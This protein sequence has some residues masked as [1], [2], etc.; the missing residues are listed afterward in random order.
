MT[1]WVLLSVMSV[2]LLTVIL[3]GWLNR[4]ALRATL[5]SY[6]QDRER[7]MDMAA[8]SRSYIWE[9]NLD[10]MH[11]YISQSV[12]NVLG[13]EPEEIIGKKMIYDMCVENERDEAKAFTTELLA[14]GREIGNME[15]RQAAK[16]GRVIW[17]LINGR[18]TYDQAGNRTGF[19]GL[20]IDITER[21]HA[22]FSSRAIKERYHSIM[23]ISNTGVWE[24]DHRSEKLWCSEE[25]FSMLGYDTT[26]FRNDV[27]GNLEEAWGDLICPEDQAVARQQFSD[28]FHS[29]TES[30]YENVFRMKRKGGTY[31]WIW[32]RGKMLRDT[33]G[34]PSGMIIG[35]HIDITEMKKLES[36]LYLEKEQ[37]KTTLLSIGEGVISTNKSGEIEVMNQVAEELTGWTQEEAKGRSLAQVYVIKDELTGEPVT[38]LADRVISSGETLEMSGGKT[39][40]SRN[41][42]EYP[43]EDQVTP[44]RNR[45]GIPSGV[46]IVF[47]DFS[48]QKRR[49]LEI[50]Y[51]SY[52][53]QLTGLYNRRFFE[54][55]LIR[56]DSHRN[57]P[58]TIVMLDVNGLKLINDAFGH[59]AGDALLLK[60]TE[61][62][63]NTFRDH[64]VIA[65]IGGDEFAVLLPGISPEV[66]ENR[67]NRLKNDLAMKM[68]KGVN[69]SISTGFATKQNETEDI[70]E[71]LR[72][73]DHQMYQDKVS[74]RPVIR[75]E[76]IEQLLDHFFD[77]YPDEKDHATAVGKLAVEIGEL[78]GLSYEER[79]TIYKAAIFHDI[80]KVAINEA[81]MKKEGLF[82][83][84]EREEV[85]RHPEIG[86]SILSAASEYAPIAEDVL[87]HH[88]RW[89]GNGYPN[90]LKA[91][92]IPLRA[93]ILQAAEVMDELMRH[94]SYREQRTREEALEEIKRH[95]G[96]QFDPR[97][98]KK[99]TAIMMEEKT[100]E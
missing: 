25:Y 20:D 90:G 55:E 10:G 69:V 85:E 54:E 21:K 94:V 65:R 27:P 93:R 22:E 76:M 11:T 87:A 79:Q 57:L 88:E 59:H 23:K 62:L 14:E 17:V 29:D 36:A 28:Y 80:G 61:A 30:L 47:R 100:Y 26:A 83:P 52:H 97:I 13:Y 35:L 73:A 89:D 3:H 92:D 18:P 53:D 51:L 75:K 82:T 4:R 77:R 46:V 8:N 24:Y 72:K 96:E 50:E 6:E 16:D 19:R 56:T 34:R 41:G 48:E 67:L 63:K 42:T 2:L 60:A 9:M 74:N 95:A 68:I 38:D 49:N 5:D 98:V 43:I 1:E 78:L 40:R 66:A 99:L 58:F 39:L 37:F 45:R 15:M 33:D 70:Y 91:H 12:K 31:S 71:I 64:D 86:Y 84:Q 7:F 81:I 44:I 32:S